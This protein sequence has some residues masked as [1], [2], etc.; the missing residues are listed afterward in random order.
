MDR[1]GNPL[2]KRPPSQT[3]LHQLKEITSRILLPRR[4]ETGE[5]K[6]NESQT[7]SPG[8]TSTGLPFPSS[9]VR[10]VW[11]KAEKDPGFVTFR[12]D[13]CGALIQ[14][15]KYGSL[16]RYGWE[17]DHIKPVSQGGTD[18]LSNL[19]PLQWENNRHKGDSWPDW[20]CLRKS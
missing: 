8:T 5:A 6:K 1:P 20:E 17:I 15:N 14:K 19:Q 16:S 13:C 10:A 4:E 3:F 9:V 11:E 7:R 18:D 2:M 12:K